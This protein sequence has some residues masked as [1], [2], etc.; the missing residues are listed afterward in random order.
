VSRVQIA[1]LQPLSDQAHA[2]RWVVFIDR[3]Y[4]LEIPFAF[5]GCQI[6]E[7]FS[8]EMKKGGYRKKYLRALSRLSALS[9]E[10]A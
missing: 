7:L 9:R 1:D 10:A 6:S 8:E 2:L 3:M 4:D 5:S